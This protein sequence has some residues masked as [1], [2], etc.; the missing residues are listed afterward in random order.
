MNW[1]IKTMT[2]KY[3]DAFHTIKVGFN[4]IR[5]DDTAGR[6]WIEGIEDHDHAGCIIVNLNLLMKLVL[7]FSLSL[8]CTMPLS[9][10]LPSHAKR[11]SLSSGIGQCISR[12]SSGS[13]WTAAKPFAWLHPPALFAV[14]CLSTS[15]RRPFS[16]RWHFQLWFFWWILQLLG[17]SL[18]RSRTSL[19]F[20]Q[21]HPPT[22]TTHPSPSWDPWVSIP[23]IWPHQT[24]S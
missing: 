9:S 6:F 8:S 7:N 19:G 14:V 21:I 15:E 1:L 2:K 16:Q 18:L 12:L 23:T 4:W 5:F 10:A 3:K 17:S 22:S 13:P 20:A 11:Q 24:R